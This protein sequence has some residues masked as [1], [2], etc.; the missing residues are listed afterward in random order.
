MSK[1][2]F[3]GL[4]HL[5]TLSLIDNYLTCLP[6]D[7][8]EELSH[9]LKHLDL[10]KNKITN[11]CWV[12]N[13]TQLHL[14]TLDLSNNPVS[15][16]DLSLFGN[17]TLSKVYLRDIYPK[18]SFN[19]FTNPALK[20]LL[21]SSENRAILIVHN[22][23]LFSPELQSF[24]VINF[25]FAVPSIF[26]ASCKRL[27]SLYV[28]ESELLHEDTEISVPFP[29]L[30]KLTITRCNMISILGKFFEIPT[31]QYLDLSKNN[32]TN[33]DKNQFRFLTNLTYLNLSGNRLTNLQ[34]PRNLLT[35]QV[36]DISINKL[37]AI[38]TIMLKKKS[39]HLQHLAVG[40]NSFNCTCEVEPLQS[41]ILSNKITYVDPQLPVVCE[42]VYGRMIGFNEFNLDCSLHREIYVSIGVA[43]LALICAI[44]GV[45]TFAYRYRWL[46]RYKLFVLFHQRRYQRYADR[47]DD[48]D[49]ID[50]ETEN[51][52]DGEELAMRRRYHAYVAY[53]M[54]NEDWVDEQLI[55]NLEEGPEQFRLCLKARDLP[56]NRPIF[57]IVY[58]VIYH[59]RKTIAVLSEQFMDDGLCDYQLHVARMRL[60]KDNDDVLIL[61]Q[62]G[63]IPDDKVTLLLRQIL[64]HKEVMK[65]PDDPV[66][67]DLFWGNLRVKLGKPSQVD[68]RYE[69]V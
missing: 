14:E 30:E 4:T 52:V 26:G 65:W 22:I 16:L 64:C 58:H 11:T 47:H 38:P 56:A 21:V 51:N 10:S 66:G 39:G 55:P 19:L 43:S 49:I 27:T 69:N 25:A 18:D 53:H 2:S 6:W 3:R 31:L 36:L 48:A 8:L 5:R 41:F 63:E 46:I 61:V 29:C 54:D 17:N 23:Y 57:N 24:S 13:M 34:L 42:S 33:I 45:G 44:V 67:Q 15:V 68:R 60:T 40:N 35:L 12:A 20:I 1:Y 9:H 59:S 28:S 50:D 7:S 62:L 32:I 37:P